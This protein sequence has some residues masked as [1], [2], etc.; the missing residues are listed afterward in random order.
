MIAADLFDV[1]LA[2]LVVSVA[3]FAKGASNLEVTA[4]T[5][6]STHAQSSRARSR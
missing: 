4:G 5:H 3:A 6:A 2:A 1:G